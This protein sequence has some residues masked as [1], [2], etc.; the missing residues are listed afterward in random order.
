MAPLLD[1][2]L[3]M[4]MTHIEVSSGLQSNYLNTMRRVDYYSVIHNGKLVIRTSN[5]GLAVKYYSAY[6]SERVIHRL[7][8]G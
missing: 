7:S 4:S 3:N 6:V 8:T 5:R 2:T 1:L